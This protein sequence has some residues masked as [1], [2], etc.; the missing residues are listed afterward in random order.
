MTDH[1]K[2]SET[3]AVYQ[4]LDR[5]FAGPLNDVAEAII[6]ALREQAIRDGRP[7]CMICKTRHAPGAHDPRC[8]TCDCAHDYHES[9]DGRCTA[10]AHAWSCDCPKYVPMTIDAARERYLAEQAK[11]ALAKFEKALAG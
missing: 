3:E 6:Y 5:L 7:W 10:G 11:E 2:E 8:A 1:P 4:R 9:G